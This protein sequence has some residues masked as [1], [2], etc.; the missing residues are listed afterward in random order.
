MLIKLKLLEKLSYRTNNEKKI[1]DLR[2]G[3]RKF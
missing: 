2:L 1:S 3:Y